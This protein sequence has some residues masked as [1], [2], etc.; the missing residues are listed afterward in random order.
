MT[1]PSNESIRGSMTRYGSGHGLR[2]G[3][4]NAIIPLWVGD[5]D[6]ERVKDKRAGP[7]REMRINDKMGCYCT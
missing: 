5:D 1:S 4:S 6:D 2:I 3:L 7:H